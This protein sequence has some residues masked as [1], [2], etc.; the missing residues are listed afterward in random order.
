MNTNARKIGLLIIIGVLTLLLA[1]P[2]AIAGNQVSL[3][4]NG[5]TIEADVYVEKGV[6]YISVKSLAKLPGITIEQEGYVPLRQFF[7]ARGG[8][9]SW[10]AKNNQ[11]V[12]S[13][14]EKA[15]GWTADELVVKSTELL[16]EAN[17]YRMKGTALMSISVSGAGEVPQ[18]PQMEMLMEGVFQ[19]EPLA[20]YMKQS[21]NLSGDTG[22]LT[23][24]ELAVLGLDGAV[25]TEMVWLD[26]A[27]YQK[28][29]HFDQW[30]VQDLAG[31][32]MMGE[33]N[34]LIQASP[35]Q[36]LEMMRQFG[37]IYIFG[38]DAVIDGREYY[39]VKNYVDSATF[40]K[41]MEEL[42]GGFELSESEQEEMTAVNREIQMAFEAML[43]TMEA[44]YY[45]VTYIN[46]ET[47]LTERMV[48]EMDMKYSLPGMSPESPMSF[49]MNMKGDYELYDFET[50][51]QLPD[52]SNAMTQRE[53]YEQMINM[54]E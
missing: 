47:L 37:I 12:I 13:W 7:E 43:D 35:Q 1:A 42:L 10:D 29:P 51:I 24:D 19:Q 26:N 25:V 11:V 23:P 52:V 16:Q 21:M 54:M 46:K 18:L 41:V 28:M 32:D 38:E 45:V 2:S 39:T 31:M 48:F 34:N 44:T 4:L 33:L 14:R 36:S 5:Q 3:S 53:L 49:A 30:V 20:M 22:E 8:E 6:S 40:K 50:E 27:I 15:D 17:T 9:V